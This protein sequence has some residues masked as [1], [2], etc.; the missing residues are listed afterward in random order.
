MR[1]PCV[2][3]AS[4]SSSSCTGGSVAASS[5]PSVGWFTKSFARTGR[6][7]AGPLLASTMARTRTVW[8]NCPVHRTRQRAPNAG[9]SRGTHGD[10]QDELLVD[11]GEK[12][13]VG[14]GVE[15]LGG[16]DAA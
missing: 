5:K 4:V 10:G 11:I 15:L 13:R 14:V 16:D 7:A 1:A 2:S 12:E 6:C 9:Q 8:L 3:C